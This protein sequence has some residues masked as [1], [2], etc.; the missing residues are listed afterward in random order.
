MEA[1]RKHLLTL[2]AVGLALA[3][4]VNIARGL[5]GT[6][7]AVDRGVGTHS[8]L[9]HVEPSALDFGHVAATDQFTWRIPVRNKLDRPMRIERFMTSC[10]CAGVEPA[11][12][13]LQAGET[14]S[15]L[16]KLDLFQGR[17]GEATYRFAERIYP[18]VSGEFG[19]NEAW[20]VRGEVHEVFQFEPEAVSFGDETIAGKVP[21]TQV[22]TAVPYQSYENVTCR[23]VPDHASVDVSKGEDGSF[24][25][26]VLP[27]AMDSAGD[28]SF[29]LLL[30]PRWS[31]SDD[32]I[33]GR[34]LP[35]GERAIYVSYEV[36]DPVESLPTY[37]HL[38]FVK[39]GQTREE[40]CSLRPREGGDIVVERFEV[41]S[42]GATVVSH[43]PLATSHSEF[44]F[45]V[46]CTPT[47]EGEKQA[48]I[49]FQILHPGGNK[50]S[51]VPPQRRYSYDFHLHY[52][53]QDDTPSGQ[54]EPDLA[55]PDK[56]DEQGSRL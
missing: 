1:A 6:S 35:V 51:E 25:L 8:A 9:L 16:V 19:V 54:N 5:F 42:S 41:I 56:A 15:F 30:T 24:R 4:A 47:S 22:I 12:A 44:Q 27:H 7:G 29:R 10:S 18:V 48:S 49:R 3:I 55:A 38:G 33:F 11:S 17:T 34:N 31:A 45:R 23:A 32:K 13:E 36:V 37:N 20:V 52:R 2:A 53:A 50:A 28:H 46:A 14:Q 26:H 40:S 43:D 39:I 21:D